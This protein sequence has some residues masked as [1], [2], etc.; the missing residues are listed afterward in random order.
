MKKIYLRDFNNQGNKISC[1]VDVKDGEDVITSETIEFRNEIEM[2][3]RLKAIKN[4]ANEVAEAFPILKS[5]EGE[6]VEPE[7][8]VTEVDKEQARFHK[9]EQMK[10]EVDLGLLLESEYATELGKV[11]AELASAN[12]LI[13]K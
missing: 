2:N 4:T 11:K 7:A 12:P 5:K 6:W 3:S 10:R 13:I 8:V 9:L 1:T